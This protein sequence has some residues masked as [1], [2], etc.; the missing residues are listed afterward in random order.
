MKKMNILQSI[1]NKKICAVVR[2]N[3]KKECLKIVNALYDGG[4]RIVEIVLNPDLQIEVVEKLK[5]KKD[6]T[7]I[8]GGIITAREAISLIDV[9]VSVISSP[10][11]QTKLIRLCYSRMVD[12]IATV[13]T[14]NEAYE[15]WRFRL[16]LMKLH[17]A[18][19]LGGAVYIK[20]ILKTMPFLNI[21]AAGG[22]EI[23]QIE[24]YIN[25]G[26]IG[27]CIGRDLYQ[28]FDTILDYEKIKKNAE[29]AVKSVEKLVK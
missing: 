11:M 26:A 27:V 14:A 13:S 10:V 16:P 2:V 18:E 28:K 8:A 4:I 5:E 24:D 12:T 15:A 9:G 17:P 7:V 25:A 23:N 22:I 21:V 6:L 19:A 29:K 1:K 20:E 3:D